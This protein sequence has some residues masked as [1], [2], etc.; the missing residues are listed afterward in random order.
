MVAF[1]KQS[2]FKVMIKISTGFCVEEFSYNNEA[3]AL[4]QRSTRYMKDLK[5]K[6]DSGDSK[7]AYLLA[8]QLAKRKEYYG[9]SFIILCKRAVHIF[10]SYQNPRHNLTPYIRYRS[11]K[12]NGVFRP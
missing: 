11:R 4:E 1:L 10:F 7:A 12:L 8:R 2:V 3:E 9:I 5:R 6:A